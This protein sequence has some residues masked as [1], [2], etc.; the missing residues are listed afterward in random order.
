MDRELYLPKSWTEDRDRCRD[1]AIPD[2][3]E[4]AT[5]T[6]QAQRMLARA[7]DAGIPTVDGISR[8]DVL[9]AHAHAEA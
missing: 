7:V 4:F 8:A 5:T 3:V 2:E 6:V 9:L 1:A